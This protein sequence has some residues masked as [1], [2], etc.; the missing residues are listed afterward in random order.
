MG[1]VKSRFV[2]LRGTENL[3]V[4]AFNLLTKPKSGIILRDSA[5]VA[6]RIEQW[7]P[8]PRVK[9]RFLSGAFQ[10]CSM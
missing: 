10:F 2:S 7:I 6:Q 5:P 8:D 1:L 9:V 4:P 3:Y